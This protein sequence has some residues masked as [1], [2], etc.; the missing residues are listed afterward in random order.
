VLSNNSAVFN[1]IVP[2]A[3]LVKSRPKYA[4]YVHAHRFPAH[5]TF[6]TSCDHLEDDQQGVK[7]YAK[8]ST[9]DSLLHLMTGDSATLFVAVAAENENCVMI[10]PSHAVTARFTSTKVRPHSRTNERLHSAHYQLR[11]RSVQVSPWKDVLVTV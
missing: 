1:Q 8:Q 4:P 2:C 11:S 5:R 9:D 10:P 6:E 7:L 3:I